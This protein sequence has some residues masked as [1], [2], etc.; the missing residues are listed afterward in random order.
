MRETPSLT[1]PSK[2]TWSSS[3]K[4]ASH[5]PSGPLFSLNGGGE[6]GGGKAVEMFATYS[7]VDVRV[8]PGNESDVVA[9]KTLV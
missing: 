8:F 7:I 4:P 3:G 5:F 2:H 6:R 9:W 1:V